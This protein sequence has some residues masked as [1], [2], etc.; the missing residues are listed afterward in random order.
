MEK[1]ELVQFQE[2]QTD[3]FTKRIVFKEDK[4]T[5]FVLNFGPGQQLPVHK[6]PG[7]SVYILFL[8]GSGIV[9]SDGREI[10]VSQ[11]DVVQISGD[12]DFSYR[13]GEGSN[14]SL[15]VTLINTPGEQYAQNI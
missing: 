6:H 4:H 8:E 5:V 15:Y 10:S 11:G 2:Y 3:R 14:S 7:A 9:T 1:K 13:S 12:E